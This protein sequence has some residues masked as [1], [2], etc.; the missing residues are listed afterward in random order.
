[1]S[2]YQAAR[3]DVF[4]RVWDHFVTKGN[5]RAIINQRCLYRTPDGARCAVGL[6]IP[7]EEYSPDIESRGV[8]RVAESCPTVAGIAR[9]CFG[10]GVTGLAFL[11]AMQRAHDE[12]TMLGAKDIA[13]ALRNLAASYSLTVPA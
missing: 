1:M 7:D 4:N 3:Q 6:L 11:D 13:G 8:S 9:S 5:P 12:P 10:G 2:D